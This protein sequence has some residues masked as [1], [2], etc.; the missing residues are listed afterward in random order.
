MQLVFKVVNNYLLCFST[1]TEFTQNFEQILP[2]MIE[3]IDNILK[4]CTTT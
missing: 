3:F 1:D 2:Y 4:G